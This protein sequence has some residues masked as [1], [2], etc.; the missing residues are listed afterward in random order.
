[1]RQ[2]SPII[3]KVCEFCK[4]KFTCKSDKRNIN[5]RFC[6]KICTAKN[7]G[8]NN[9]GN[10]CPWKKQKLSIAT[11]CICNIEKSSENFTKNK[12]KGRG[13]GYKCKKCQKEIRDKI[14]YPPQIDG[15][16]KCRICYKEK[17][18][19]N[20]SACS[21]IKTGRSSECKV[22]ENK[23]KVTKLHSDIETRLK[24]NCRK[25]V[26]DALNETTKSVRT[27]E[28]IGCSTYELK[29]H[30]EKQ[31]VD[32]MT[33]ENYGKWQIDHIIPCCSFNLTD[34]KEQRKCFHFS[35]TQPLWKKDNL[36]KGGKI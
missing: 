22:C 11:C 16:Q 13:I 20:F 5:R 15:K 21:K 23:R 4:N 25:R 17:E 30:L 34:E 18:F 31:S 2:K 33:W 26:R 12:S 6:S 32:G 24:E 28:L 27:F 7:N 3:E 10:I 1:M 35:N 19:I 9:L 14:Y 29:L 8:K 36:I